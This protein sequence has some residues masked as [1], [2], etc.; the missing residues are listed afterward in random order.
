MKQVLL[1]AAVIALAGAFLAF[2]AN[3][4]SPRGLT[5]T[6]NYFPQPTHISTPGSGTN[7][8][9]ATN[10]VTV[11]TDLATKLQ[12]EGLHLATTNEVVPLFH[13]PGYAQGQIVFIDARDAKEYE[14]GHIP[15]AY[16]LDYFHPD[17]D[18]PATVQLCQA[19]DRIVIYCNGGNCDLS[20]LTADLLASLGVSKPK[21]WV[22]GG[23]LPEWAGAGLPVELG[24]RGSGQLRET[25]R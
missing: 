13:D 9:A 11:E 20:E 23:G 17:A 3:A 2:V 18:L 24:Q 22:Y 14:A 16:H 15:G 6:R 12:N 21:L 25:K 4:I 8:V 7:A 1:E 10:P 5:L 19:A